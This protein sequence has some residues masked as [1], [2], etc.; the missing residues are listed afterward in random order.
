M[1][2][3]QGC[4]L[5]VA[6]VVENIPTFEP[7]FLSSEGYMALHNDVSGRILLVPVNRTQHL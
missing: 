1:S 2:C 3:I 6:V 5:K 4:V 7:S